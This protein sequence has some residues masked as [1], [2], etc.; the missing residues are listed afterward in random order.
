MV[1]LMNKQSITGHWKIMADFPTRDGDYL[2]VFRNKN[3]SIDSRPDIWS[4]YDGTW[5]ALYGYTEDEPEY[6]LDIQMPK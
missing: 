1:T 6:W 3:G 5:E 2:V 4:F